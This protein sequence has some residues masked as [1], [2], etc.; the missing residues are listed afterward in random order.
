MRSGSQRHVVGA[1]VVDL[2]KFLKNLERSSGVPFVFNTHTRALLARRVLGTEWLALESF[3]ELL[4]GLN[5]VVIR[6][7][8]QR[9]LEIGSVGGAAM[10]GLQKAYGVQGDPKSSVIA[11]RH[12]WRAYYDFGRL[13]CDATS[14][15]TVEFSVED[16]VDMSMAHGMIT[17]G[18]SVAAAR[19]AGSRSV[20]VTVLDR[21]WKGAPKFR[22]VVRF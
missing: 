5:E 9:A 7:E 2:I 10:R 14:D 4:A 21:P 13:T 15:S 17:A 18:W 19:A 20:G 3:A 12:A 6:G 22:F 8:E 1:V 16:Y 11:M